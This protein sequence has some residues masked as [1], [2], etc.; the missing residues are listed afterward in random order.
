MSMAVRIAKAG[1][2][3]VDILSHME[4]DSYYGNWTP[5]ATWFWTRT[6][7]TA[8]AL[9][10]VDGK[11]IVGGAM[12]L[13]TRDGSIYVDTMF[14]LPKYKERG[15]GTAFLERIIKAANGRRIIADVDA[16]I[17]PVALFKKFGFRE[18]K[19]LPNYYLDGDNYILMERVGR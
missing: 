5:Y 19:R 17:G 4:I 18:K 2:K 13:P 15:I 16:D 9:K 11:K 8:Y 3:D 7:E 14:V 1:H 6:I 10:A 12:A